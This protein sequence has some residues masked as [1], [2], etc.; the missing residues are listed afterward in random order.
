MQLDNETQFRWRKRLLTLS[1]ALALAGS[2]YASTPKEVAAQGTTPPGPDRYSV[3]VVDYTKYFWWMFYLGEDEIECKIVTD[4]EG[5]PTP[6][7]V[8]VDCG[9]DL[10]EEWIEQKPCIETD[11]TLCTGLYLH[12]AGT[13]P[14]QKEIATPLPPPTVQV[15][16]ENCDPV[17]TSSDR[18]SVE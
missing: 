2:V 3:T 5:L 18:K 16:L 12:L 11:T 9:E 6:G 17:Y 1:L 10:Y 7:D 13:K 4:H 8:F 14:A 15:T